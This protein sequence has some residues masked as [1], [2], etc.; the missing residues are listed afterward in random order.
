MEEI[1]KVKRRRGDRIDATRVRDLDGMH[2]I[3]PAM[4]PNRADNEAFIRELID[5][6]AM[7]AY[8]AKKNAENPEHRY[9]MFQV[10]LSAIGRVVD[11][12]PRM[13]RFIKGEKYYDRNHITFSLIAKKAFSDNG[14]ESIAILRYDPQS[15]KSSIDEMHD[16]LC[17]FV[18]NIRHKDKTDDTTSTIDLI[19]KTGLTHF[20]M[21]LLARLDDHGHMPTQLVRED[22]YNSTVWVSNLGSI[23]LNAGYHHLTNWGTNSLFVV[24]GERH[25]HPYFDDDGTL[26]L[27][28]AIEIGLTLDERI[29]DGYYYARTIQ[30]LKQLLANPELLDTPAKEALN[31]EN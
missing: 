23:Q 31:I 2:A 7:E 17:D 13:N 21:R 5:V 9:T 30:L 29:A 10:I 28:P 1:Q 22:P 18:H 12:R 26:S 27:K 3:I 14:A 11:M 25:M 24:I 20:I 6:T 19:V 8:V 4:L 16:K 15:E